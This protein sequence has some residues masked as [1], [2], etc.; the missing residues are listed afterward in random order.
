M[1]SSIWRAAAAGVERSGTSSQARVSRTWAS[2]CR[3]CQCSTAAHRVVELHPANDGIGR[4]QVDGLEQRAAAALSSP[5]DRSAEASAT[6]TDT[7]RSVSPLGKRRSAASNQRAAASGARALADLPASS[8]SSIAALVALPRRMLHVVGALGGLCPAGSEELRGARM[9]AQAASRRVTSRT[10][11]A[12]RADGGRRTG[13]AP[14]WGERGPG[15][16]GR[17]V[18]RGPRRSR[19]PQ[20]PRRGRA[21]TARRPRPRPPRAA[22]GRPA[23]RRALRRW[24]RP[25]PAGRPRCPRRQRRSWQGR[26]PAPRGPAARDRRGCRLRGCRRLPPRG[27]ARRGAAWP[28]PD[29]GGRDRAS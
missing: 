24:R 2:S 14:G 18:P 22:A 1:L 19:R 25:P 11:R 26:P 28:R 27:R 13:A 4:E 9:R 12:A 23:A 3:P 7:C 15:R 21:R 20:S 16:A 5:T 6:R 8:R 10:P 29:R 17:R